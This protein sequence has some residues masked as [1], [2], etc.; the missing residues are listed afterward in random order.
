MNHA[1]HTAIV[2]SGGGAYGAFAVGALKVLFAGRSPATDFKPV[3]ADILTGTSVGAFN[4]AMVAG[5]PEPDCLDAILR[6]ESIWIDRIADRPGGNNNGVFRVVGDPA[7]YIDPNAL[8]SPVVT[9]MNLV[10]DSLVLGRYFISRTANFLTSDGPLEQRLISLFNLGS[11]IDSRPYSRLLHDVVRE[12]DVLQ[13]RKLLRII[14]TDWI[15]GTAVHFSNSDFHD[16]LGL[17]AIMASTAIPGVFPP[18]RIGTDIYVDG[19]VVENTPLKPALDCG[20]THLHVIYFDPRPQYV[21]LLAEPNTLDTLLRVYHVMLGTKLNEDI[22][23][24]RWINS[25]LKAIS[26][27][28][29]S[30]KISAVQA[31]DLVRAAGKILN[32]DSHYEPITIHRYF[33]SK[34]LGGELGALGFGLD[35]IVKMIQ[36]GEQSALLHDCAESGCVIE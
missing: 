34:V 22:E 6:L 17:S 15:T 31:R 18:V 26:G 16:G 3:E 35:P 33:P 32:A 5:A 24:A 11:F 23:T 13:S 1:D 7:D 9:A 36:E 8:R 21:P 19:G 29:N 12:E 27:L 30:E 20:A 10:N 28:Q 2:L 4:A 14:A 25:G